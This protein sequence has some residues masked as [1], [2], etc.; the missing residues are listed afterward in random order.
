MRGVPL[1]EA[2]SQGGKKLHLS[3]MWVAA[4]RRINGAG[5]E[6][7]VPQFSH[8]TGSFCFPSH[9]C[10]I[11]TRSVPKSPWLSNPPWE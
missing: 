3:L 1:P 2:Q 4:G 11:P 6:Q 7:W 8:V 5:L 9:R 10:L